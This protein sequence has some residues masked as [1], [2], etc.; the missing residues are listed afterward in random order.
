MSEVLFEIAG[1]EVTITGVYGLASVIILFLFMSLWI[2]GRKKRTG[3]EIFAGQVMN[4]IG[5]GLLPALAVLKAFQEAGTGAGSRVPE[6]L[7]S[8]P[9]LS[10]N[11]YYMPGRIETTAA[12]ALFILLCL[13]LILSKEAF[14]DNGDLI[15]IS[16]CIWAAI[17]LV[18]EDFRREPMDLFRYTSCGTILICAA[19]WSARRARHIR[20]PAR[21][22]IE[23]AVVFVC[24]LINL[25]TTKK[26]LSMGSEIADFAVKTGS[27]A[28][29]LLLTLMTGEEYR[30]ILQKTAPAEQQA[31]AIG[32]TQ[33]VAKAMK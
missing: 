8:I 16:V 2:I 26:I 30:R 5:F 24:I 17:R 31:T 29:M 25:L 10:L 14:P 9:W 22:M 6:P 18:T 33:V 12:A 11:G 7:P 3:K 19:A 4:G 27:A 20:I 13:Q 23:P 15:M 1:M 32:D 21:T 28:I